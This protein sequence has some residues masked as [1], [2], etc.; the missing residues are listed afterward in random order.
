MSLERPCAESR[1]TPVG[2]VTSNALAGPPPCPTA[3]IA[4]VATP[5]AAL[6]SAA[7]NTSN[8]EFPKPWPK[9][10]TGQPPAGGAPAGTISAKPISSTERARGV[11]RVGVAAITRSRDSHPGALKEPNAYVPA[12]AVAV[13]GTSAGVSAPVVVV[14]VKRWIRVTEAAGKACSMRRRRAP[15]RRPTWS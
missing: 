12:D 7:R 1:V 10:A 8:F 11:R 6:R 15:G 3:S 2:V 9:T 4:I 5:R 14:C 13:F